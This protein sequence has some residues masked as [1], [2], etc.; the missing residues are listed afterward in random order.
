VDI[1]IYRPT[2][3][4]KIKYNIYYTHWLGAVAGGDSLSAAGIC[5]VAVAASAVAVAAAAAGSEVWRSAVVLT[6]A[7]ADRDLG[8]TIPS[9][10]W[11]CRLRRPTPSNQRRQCCCRA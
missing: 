7:A 6:V 4:Y 11:R 1:F 8:A 9:T 5:F 2:I 3:A 10:P